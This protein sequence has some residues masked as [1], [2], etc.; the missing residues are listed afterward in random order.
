MFQN[1]TL[2]ALVFFLSTPFVAEAA[3][4]GK[5]NDYGGD[6]G[7]G[8]GFHEIGIL[9]ASTSAEQEHL[10]T[11]IRRAGYRTGGISTAEMSRAWELGLQYGYRSPGS[12]F[13]WLVRP[14]YF[15]QKTTG[16]NSGGSY[17]YGVTGFMLFPLVRVIPL[18]NNFMKFYAQGGI[19][20]G[21]AYGKIQE[22][23][24]SVEMQGDA[25][26]SQLGVGLEFCYEGVH[27]LAFETNY[28]YMKMARNISTATSGTFDS[29][30]VTQSQVNSEVEMSGYDLALQIGGLQFALG[31]TAHF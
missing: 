20:Y 21:R 13:E 22:A 19:G 9:G 5:G 15:Y 30:S 12:M 29:S 31:Y 16:S 7:S 23:D 4:R 25:Y 10:N 3:F 11:L 28:R 8:F 26:G 1:A 18:E 2:I 6:L 14:S 24:A 27:C 17:D